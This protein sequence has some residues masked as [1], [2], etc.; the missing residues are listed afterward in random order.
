MTLPLR[1]DS[2]RGCGRHDSSL[3]TEHSIPESGAWYRGLSKGDETVMRMESL[4][5]D[6]AEIPACSL[7]STFWRGERAK[8]SDSLSRVGSSTFD[9]QFFPDRWQGDAGRLREPGSGSSL[10]TGFEECTVATL[11][12]ENFQI[13][14]ENKEQQ[15]VQ[16]SGASE[17]ITLSV[18]LSL[19]A[20]GPV[21]SPNQRDRV[22]LDVL[23]SVDKVRESV[24]GASVT[25]LP[26][27][28]DGAF[29]VV[30]KAMDELA[31][32]PGSKKAL[33]VV[34]DGMI[35]SGSRAS[36]V[37]EPKKL[38]EASRVSP[39][40]L[41]MLYPTSVLPPPAFGD[42]STSALGYYLEQAAG[43]AGGKMV[44]GQIENDLSK[45]ATNLRD[46]LK[47]MYVLG[48]QP[49]NAAKDGKWRKLTVKVSAPEG[50]KLKVNSKSRY[51]VPKA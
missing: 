36:T 43:F 3:G 4:G 19:S 20:S 10:C 14:E 24:P 18:V 8:S 6:F 23:G 9:C 33:V 31:R 15:I 12:K 38:M 46:T 17:P 7:N 2:S 40:P 26:F 47:N 32:K 42:G 45:V 37:T 29:E 51:F 16:F 22:S 48:Y 34:S 27:D 44:F 50:A 13:L 39:F 1:I 5:I 30:S 35:S 49:A 11:T 28:S 25:Q 41:Y 21:K